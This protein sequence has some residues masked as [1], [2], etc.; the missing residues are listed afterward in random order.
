MKFPPLIVK[1]VDLSKLYSI[2]KNFYFE[3]KIFKINTKFIQIC[4]KL[5]SNDNR[6]ELGN[7]GVYH[8]TLKKFRELI[9]KI[10]Y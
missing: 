4:R 7:Q 5:N 3:N 6:L 8:G 10:P 9:W 1:I 2:Y